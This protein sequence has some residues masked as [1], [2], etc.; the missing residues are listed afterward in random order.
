M[1]VHDGWDSKLVASLEREVGAVRYP[2]MPDEANPTYAAWKPAILHELA[3]LD[4]G[5][6]V[7][8]HSLG[9]TMLVNVLA[10]RPPKPRP[11]GICLIAAPFIGE[12][13]WP[14]DELSPRTDWATRLPEIPLVMFH[15]DRDETVPVAHL[16]LYA[17]AI[18]QAR[19]HVIAGADHQL[20]ND[21]REVARALLAIA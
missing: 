3:A 20:N 4:E 8:G 19:V 6:L 21:L 2:R 1:A 13:G 7:V 17:R 11:G 18:P 10:D 15:G 5:A 9:G 14:S 16:A 12:G